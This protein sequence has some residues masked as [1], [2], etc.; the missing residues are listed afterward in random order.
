[1]AMIGKGTVHTEKGGYDSRPR[2]VLANKSVATIKT[3]LKFAIVQNLK[4]NIILPKIY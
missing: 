4:V 3:S 2:G 1:M